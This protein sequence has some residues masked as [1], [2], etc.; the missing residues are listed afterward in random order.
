MYCRN[1]NN[2]NKHKPKCTVSEETSKLYQCTVCGVQFK[3]LTSLRVGGIVLYVYL[4]VC[5]V[6][7]STGYPGKMG[8][9]F[10]VRDKWCNFEYTGKVGEYM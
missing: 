10:P 4:H 1:L 6:P 5:M 8:V 3:T 7:T 9:H 2:M